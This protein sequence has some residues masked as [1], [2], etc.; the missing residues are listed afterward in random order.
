M[1]RLRLFHEGEQED[2][3]LLLWA[4]SGGS[5]IPGTVLLMYQQAQVLVG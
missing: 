2:K 4:S 3:D 5:N 1:D